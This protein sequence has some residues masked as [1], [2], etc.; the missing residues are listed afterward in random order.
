MMILGVHIKC[1]PTPQTCENDTARFL[2]G[3]DKKLVSVAIL[4]AAFLDSCK[5]LLLL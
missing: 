2:E 1:P 3:A 5:S 4:S